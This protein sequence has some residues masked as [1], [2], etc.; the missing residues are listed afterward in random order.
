[1]VAWYD[2]T[3]RAV[4]LTSQTAVWYRSGKPPALIRWVLIRDPQG[5][6][7]PQALLCTDPSADP[8]QILEWFVLRWQL[9]VTFQEARAHLG[10]ETQRQWSDLAIA[11][12]TPILMGLFSWT[13]LA[14]HLLRQQRPSAHR[15]A[16]WYA[17]PSPTFVDAIALVRRHLWLASEG[18]SLS[19]ADPDIRKVPAALYH[20]LVD[21]LAYAAWNG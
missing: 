7:A 12:T 3:T 20:R 18:F 5:V 19:A 11:R 16:A 13:T 1:M 10:V 4:E 21:S 15:T 14:A 9:E 17:K 2:G 6:F 8:A